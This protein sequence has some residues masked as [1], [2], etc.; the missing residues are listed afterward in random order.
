[1]VGQPRP[2]RDLP[3]QHG[4]GAVP[5]TEDEEHADLGADTAVG[6][7]VLVAE[8]E[9]GEKRRQQR[10]RKR[11]SKMT[12]HAFHGPAVRGRHLR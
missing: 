12:S 4:A 11:G 2:A 8:Q 1:M 7:Q 3:D 10:E 9:L 6:G 5:K